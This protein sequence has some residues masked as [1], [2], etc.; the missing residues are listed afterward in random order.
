MP[1]RTVF[2]RPSSPDIAAIISATPRPRS[3]SKPAVRRRMSQGLPYLAATS[4]IH[5]DP[6]ESDDDDARSWI[7]HDDFGRPLPKP[8]P[9]TNWSPEEESRFAALER[10]LEG[11]DSDA[12]DSSLDLHT[13]LPHLMMRHGLLSPQS[14][15]ITQP[16]ARDSVVSIASTTTSKGAHPLK[17]T[18][19]TVKRRVRHRDGRLLRGGIGLTTGLGWSDSEDEGAPSALTRRISSLNLTSR[20]SVSSLTPSRSTTSL[21]SAPSRSSSGTSDL[22]A[23]LPSRKSSSVPSRSFARS[24]SSITSLRMSDFNEIDEFGRIT[25]QRS[26][27]P[28]TPTTKLSRR[29]ARAIPE[30]EE[31]DEHMDTFSRY[32]GGAAMLTTSP[33]MTLAELEGGG[34]RLN[35]EKSLPPIPRS[36]VFDNS[37]RSMPPPR[38]IGTTRSMGAMRVSSG[39]STGAEGRSRSISGASSASRGSIGSTQGSSSFIPSSSARASITRVSTPNAYINTAKSTPDTGASMIKTPRPLRL[40]TPTT[41]T[42]PTT[43]TTP[44][45]PAPLLLAQRQQRHSDRPA[46]P[47]PVPVPGPVPGISI[48]T[49]T[50]LPSP[51]LESRS[52]LPSTPSTPSPVTPGTADRPRPRVGTGMTYRSSVSRMRVP[53]GIVVRSP[54][55][56][57]AG[58]QKP[59]PL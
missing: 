59:I 47:V 18:R 35:R 3:N 24:H 51:L 14:R 48:N 38:S 23:S 17:D 20:P 49:H 10:Q 8:K 1:S 2:S 40:I 6:M 21:S 45:T 16:S 34:A 50:P 33:D 46:V 44:H 30:G 32:T 36:S 56:P 29:S 58:T 19:D 55:T 52:S 12:S 39:S 54:V 26:C 11:S 7:D 9:A 4:C 15:L 31:T 22:H 57:G 43:P 27:K 13:P 42:T 5:S 41:T 28:R 53:S 37:V 25:S